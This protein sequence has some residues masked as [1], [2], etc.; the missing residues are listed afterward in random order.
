MNVLESIKLALFAVKE[1]KLRAGLTL[2]SI[3][4]GIFTIISIGTMVQSLNSTVS[5]EMSSMGGN[6]FTIQRMPAIQMGGATWQKYRKRKPISYSQAKDF[7]DKMQSTDIVSFSA[8]SARKVLKYENLETDPDVTVTGAN[9]YYVQTEKIDLSEG[10]NISGIDLDYN[11]KVCIIGNDVVLDLFP[12]GGALGKKIKVDNIK[13]EIIG[14][15]KSKGSVMGQSLDNY[16]IVPVTDYLKFFA[17]FWESSLSIKV[18]SHDAETLPY[19][20][21]ESI[22]IMRS[23]RDCKPWEDNNFE[24]ITSD[25]LKEQFSGLTS[26][27]SIFGGIIGGIALLAAGVGIMNI[28]LVSVKERTKEIGIRKAVGAKRRWIMMQF[29]I[30]AVTLCQLGGIAGIIFGSVFAMVIG[31]MG[32]L[33]FALPTTWI[34]L[35]LL[36]CTFMGVF[37]GAYPAWKAA[38]LDPIDALRYE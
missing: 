33:E 38:K 29:I 15:T 4:I 34:L 36:F 7:Q 25:A 18:E 20:V 30:E 23:L 32:S 10:R 24:L 19:V 21:D 9:E 8:S 1:N 27:L 12:E 31:N 11:R 16:V 6:I 13:Y 37:F 5:G 3:S 17:N 14:V 2:L 22:G 35:S 28:M 26:Y